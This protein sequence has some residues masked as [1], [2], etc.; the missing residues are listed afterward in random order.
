MKTYSRKG[1]GIC[2]QDLPPVPRVEDLVLCWWEDI[3]TDPN[4]VDIKEAELNK[5]TI[6]IS[7]G[8][9]IS[10]DEG[11]YRIAADF[12]FDSEKEIEDCSGVTT[13]P[14]CNV[15]QLIKIEL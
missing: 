5:P 11:C 6:C 3:N 8:W 10:S 1:L 9:I 2:I 14:I 4:W 15:I 13:I 7:S 12:N